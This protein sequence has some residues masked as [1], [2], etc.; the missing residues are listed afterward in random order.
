MPTF[1]RALQGMNPETWESC[2][3]ITTSLIPRMVGDVGDDILDW[4]LGPINSFPLP[5]DL[6]DSVVPNFYNDGLQTFS[7]E[8]E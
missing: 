8:D 7:V 4:G 1:L 2:L 5:Q 3:H 6:W